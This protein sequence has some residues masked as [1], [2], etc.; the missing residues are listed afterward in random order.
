LGVE[1]GDL[2]DLGNPSQ[3]RSAPMRTRRGR[4]LQ[5]LVWLSL[6][7]VIAGPKR[8]IV[9]NA[10]V[11]IPN[12]GYKS[13][14]LFLVCNVKWLLKENEARM[15]DLHEQFDAF[16]TTIGPEHLAVW[17]ADPDDPRVAKFCTNKNF[18][19]L[20]S[21]S[22]YVLVTTKYPDPNKAPGDFLTLELGALSSAQITSSLGRLAD[23][24]LVTG[25][26]TQKTGSEQYWRAWQDSFQALRL[27]LV[28]FGDRI[29]LTIDT[30]FFK[31]E[32]AG[33][34]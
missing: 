12:E 20:P 31:L 1:G 11:P 33:V 16:G 5:T 29:K 2:C 13:W 10:S 3:I 15:Q 17:F 21:K 28:G 14:S 23:Q 19:I 25:L 30:K 4:L 7:L 24:L 9:P 32:L 8:K 22:P 26:P 6:I 34:S 27:A 18:K